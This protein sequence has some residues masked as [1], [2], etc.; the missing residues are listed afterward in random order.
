MNAT[1]P[2]EWLFTTLQFAKSPT[3][4]DQEKPHFLTL[5]TDHFQADGS[6]IVL[7]LAK[8]ILSSTLKKLL[9]IKGKL[10]PVEKST[11]VSFLTQHEKRVLIFDE[12]NVDEGPIGIDEY[13]IIALYVDHLSEMIRKSRCD[14][15]LLPFPQPVLEEN[16]LRKWAMYH[17]AIHVNIAPLP[18][19]YSSSADGK[20]SVSAGLFCDA[21]GFSLTDV[22]LKNSLPFSLQYKISQSGDDIQVWHH[23]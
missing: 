19:G 21:S 11:I 8:Y 18:S 10:S 3:S 20:I 7:H 22:S 1:H 12:E 2:I 23:K 4:P 16:F 15:F 6:H 13:V 9:I 14:T 17:S 5:I